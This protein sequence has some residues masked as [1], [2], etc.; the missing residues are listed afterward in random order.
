MS[1]PESKTTQS[2]PPLNVVL[3]QM[4]NGYWLTQAI[5][6]AANLGIADLLANGPKTLAELA[7]ASQSDQRSLRRLLRALA[8]LGIF[9]EEN[10][11]YRL[12]PLGELLRSDVPGSLRGVAMYSGDPEHYAAWGQLGLSVKTGERAFDAVF[13]ERVFDYMAKRPAIAQTFIAAMAGY[14]GPSARAV[15]DHFDSRGYRV[16]VDIGG[17][18]GR[19]LSELLA[20]NPS[21]R[22]VLYEM[23]H[24][25]ERAKKYLESRGM[26]GRT[27]V[28]AG[29][30]FDRIPSDGDLYVMKWILHDWDD[31]TALTILRNVRKAMP[32]NGRLLIAEAV[33]PED[34]EPFFGKLMDLNMLVMTGGCE[35]TRDEFA[36]LL[37]ASGFELA[38]VTATGSFVDLVEA[39]PV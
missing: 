4:I 3:T 7:Q 11:K 21:A 12:T 1:A 5:H 35:R 17:G 24:V 28:I 23:P 33:V 20:G 16:I 36:K 34:N 6:T 18:D 26:A 37:S 8:S 14:S 19:L 29:D 31:A 25:V 10:G 30:F 2:A 22:G 39:R 13:G 38:R 15:A 32:P 9:A 27:N